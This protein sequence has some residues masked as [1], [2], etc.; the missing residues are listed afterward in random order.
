MVSFFVTL[1]LLL[2]EKNNVCVCQSGALS[3][4]HSP[5]LPTSAFTSSFR[6]YTSY[7]LR[8][9]HISNMQAIADAPEFATINTYRIR[10]D[11]VRI[12]QRHQ[13]T[14]ADA[15]VRQIYNCKRGIYTP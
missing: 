13:C 2:Y 8:L 15:T 11:E 14:Y 10:T 6:L 5:S 7:F 4:M 1:L 3:P 9:I 12:T